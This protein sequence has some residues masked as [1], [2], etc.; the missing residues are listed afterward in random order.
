MDQG[1]G[2]QVR[3]RN[4][5]S[6]AW[7]EMEQRWVCS[8]SGKAAGMVQEA[9]SVC[10]LPG[11]QSQQRLSTLHQGECKSWPGS[12]AVPALLPPAGGQAVAHR[13]AFHAK[14]RGGAAG[15]I[16][17]EGDPWWRCRGPRAPRPPSERILGSPRTHLASRAPP[18]PCTGRGSG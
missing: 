6:R 1:V 18:P 16:W 10:H 2:A 3:V 12:S 9:A 4:I 11:A 5:H 15:E 13:G 7:G 8:G 14:G 17:A